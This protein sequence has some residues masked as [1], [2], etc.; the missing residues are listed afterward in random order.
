MIR[1]TSGSKTHRSWRYTVIETGVWL[2]SDPHGQQFLRNGHGTVDVTPP[3]DRSPGGTGGCRRAPPTPSA[4]TIADRRVLLL[5][6]RM[7]A[8][9]ALR[10]PMRRRLTELRRGRR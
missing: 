4:S 2:W 1:P 9:Q 3:T 7:E 6:G 5:R 10:T 8:S